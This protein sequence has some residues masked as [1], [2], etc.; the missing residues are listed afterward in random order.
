MTFLGT[1]G[2]SSSA[3]SVLIWA[4]KCIQYVS[5]KYFQFQ[6]RPHT[7]PHALHPENR[8]WILHI[9]SDFIPHI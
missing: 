8:C 7:H 2:L 4:K 3:S 5:E 1:I 6:L 9:V